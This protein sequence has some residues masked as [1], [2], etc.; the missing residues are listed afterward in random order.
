VRRECVLDAVGLMSFRLQLHLQRK[1]LE[2]ISLREVLL[3]A[4]APKSGS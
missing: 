4:A 1:L 2:Q 3:C